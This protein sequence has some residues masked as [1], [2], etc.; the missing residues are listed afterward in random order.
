MSMDI[1]NEYKEINIEILNSIKEDREDIT[2]F[3]KREEIIK[4]ILS[5]NLEKSEIKKIY[6]ENKLDILDKEL[7]ETLRNKMLSVK[8][9]LKKMSNQKQANLIY[10]NTNRITNFFSTR[11]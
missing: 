4:K 10:A 6:K 2:L 7:E 5:L 1:F 8:E 11:T 3:E 9:E